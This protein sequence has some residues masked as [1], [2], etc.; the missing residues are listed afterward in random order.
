MHFA[1]RLSD[2]TTSCQLRSEESA[3]S[4]PRRP[5]ARSR[6]IAHRKRAFSPIRP[7][8]KCSLRKER[9]HF[10]GVLLK[11]RWR[12]VGCGV[13]DAP[14][15]ARKF[16]AAPDACT[17]HCRGAACRSRHGTDGQCR[18]PIRRRT[19]KV[20][21]F[22]DSLFLA[23]VQRRARLSPPLQGVCVC[24]A[25]GTNRQC[26]PEIATAPVGPLWEPAG[27]QNRRRGALPCGGSYSGKIRCGQRR[28]PWQ[29]RRRQRRQPCRHA[30]QM[31]SE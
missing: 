16:G 20:C 15:T 10:W 28:R 25:V 30:G 29:P 6:R 11:Y 1:H 7:I 2:N 14:C 18:L 19:P 31:P 12:V 4:C 9:L 21:H 22:I 27:A 5:V 13:P 8:K 24:P 17:C 3:L 23:Q 26:L